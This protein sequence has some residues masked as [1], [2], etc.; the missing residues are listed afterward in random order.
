MELNV[1]KALILCV[2]LLLA[3]YVRAQPSFRLKAR[4]AGGPVPGPSSGNAF[5]RA[6]RQPTALPRHFVLEFRSYPG[7]EVRQELGRRGMRVLQYLPDM[8]L[9]VSSDAE[10]RL[11]GLDVIWAGALNP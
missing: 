4:R 7:P 8:G 9:M 3:P 6:G 2:C 11:A 1:K 5:G 10:P